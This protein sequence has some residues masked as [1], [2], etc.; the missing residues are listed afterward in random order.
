MQTGRADNM[1]YAPERFI[2]LREAS[3]RR[4]RINEAPRWD[5]V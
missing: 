4:E 3:C 5:D 2:T 1:S